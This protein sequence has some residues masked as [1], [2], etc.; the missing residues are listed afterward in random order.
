VID[1]TASGYKD[2]HRV[3]EVSRDGKVNIDENMEPQ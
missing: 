3:I 1:V 2:L